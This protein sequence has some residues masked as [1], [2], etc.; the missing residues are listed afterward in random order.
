[1]VWEKGW[2]AV[3]YAMKGFS[4]SGLLVLFLLDRADR[5]WNASGLATRALFLFDRVI[6]W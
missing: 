4:G 1:M 2:Q 6:G 3:C 5:G